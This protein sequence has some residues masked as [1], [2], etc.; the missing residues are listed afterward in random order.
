MEK[1]QKK[2]LVPVDFSPSSDAAIKVAKSFAAMHGAELVLLNAIES[3]APIAEFF[4]DGDL[5][6]KKTDFAHKML[7]K[8]IDQHSSSDLIVSKL[9]KEGKPY[10]AILTAAEEL[11]VEMIVMGTWGTHA[12]ESGMIGSNVNKVVRSARIPVLT[13]TRNPDTEAFGKILIT[14]DPEFGIREMR[15]LLEMYHKAYNPVVELLSIAS[16]EKEVDE[17]KAYLAKQVA[18][19]HTQGIK[20][21][22]PTVKVGG[23]I[24]DAIL[25]HAKDGGHEM[26]WMETH[27]RSGISGWILGSITEEV[28]QYSPVP[29][30]SLHPERT[31]V[32]RYYYHANS[33]F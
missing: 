22:I 11:K 1:R 19:L 3:V 30:M 18:A 2:I 14:V 28:L 23:I 10:N 4:A 15:H 20:D 6:I 27:G 12:I 5:G 9:V 32:A 25:S 29:V 31:P 26:I 7:D 13:V 16:N 17:L 24:S 8:L 21:V 33:A